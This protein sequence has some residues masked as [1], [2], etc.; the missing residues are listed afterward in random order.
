V[1]R[2]VSYGRAASRLLTIIAL[3]GALLI[4]HAA[5]LGVARHAPVPFNP[6]DGGKP[7]LPNVLVTALV[8]L[9][10]GTIYAGGHVMVKSTYA[11]ANPPVVPAG[12]MWLVSHDQGAHWTRRVSTAN[13]DIVRQAA[14]GTLPWTDHHIWPAD[15]T[16]NTLAVA[17]RQPR[18][19]YAA[20]CTGTD[21]L[22]LSTAGQHRLL[23]STDGGATWSDAIVFHTKALLYTGLAN[24]TT[25]IAKTPALDAVLKAGPSELP[26][27]ALDVAIDPVDNNRVYA[28]MSG[29]GVLRSDN[30]GRTWRYSDTPQYGWENVQCDLLIDP[31]NTS[32]VYAVDRVNGRVYR[33]TDAGRTWALASDFGEKSN[34]HLYDPTLVNGTLYLTGYKGIYASGDQGRHWRLAIPDPLPGTMVAGIRGNGGWIAAF[35]P[36][37]RTLSTGVYGTQDGHPWRLLVDTNAYGPAHLGGA[38]DY[39]VMQGDAYTRLWEDH[40]AHLVFTSG[41]IGGL[42]RWRSGI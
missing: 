41:A 32:V 11:F 8:A 34:Q 23:R 27:Q 15:F 10:N 13:V 9:P 30:A 29:I 4:P 37:A 40:A 39:D 26:G 5:A 7:V 21:A 12:S 33:S 38:M 6:L 36:T 20:G 31:R 14:S 17:P 28:C 19:I 16:A 42:W 25:N 2:R 24:L 3:T 22:C 35:S 18:I 1:I